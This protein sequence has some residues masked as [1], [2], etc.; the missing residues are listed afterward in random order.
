MFGT[1]YTVRHSGFVVS[2]EAFLRRIVQ[3]SR[4]MS[5]M[6]ATVTNRAWGTWIVCITLFCLACGRTPLLP[7]TCAIAIDPSVLDFGVVAPADQ[8]TESVRVSNR[9][10]RDCHLSGVGLVSGSDLWFA[11]AP[12][13]PAPLVVKSDDSAT[14]AVTFSPVSVS[15]PLQRTGVLVF[16]TD[17][18][19]HGK[20][21]VPLVAQIQSHCVLAV[22]PSA[23]DF[24]HVHLDDTAT[25]SVVVTNVGS[26]SCEI[27]KLV[28][29][30]GSDPQFSLGVNQTDRFT[31]APG[32]TQSIALS[33][34][35]VDSAVPHHRKGQLVFA[36]TDPKRLTVTIPLSADIDV[37]CALT[38]SPDNLNFGNV[39]LNTTAN[40]SVKLS[41]D[42]SD[43]CQVSG[44]RIDPSSDVG[45]SLAVGQTFAF[46]VEPGASKAINIKFG[47]FDSEPPHQKNGALLLQTGN[48][49]APQASVPLSAYVNTVCVEASRWI[50]TVDEDGMFSRFDPTTSTFTD[51][52]MLACPTFYTPFSMA[53]DQNAVAW[54]LYSDGSLFRVDASTGKCQA[55]N[56][57]P[58][59]HGL[60]VFGMGFVFD[61][62]TGVDTLFIADGAINSMTESELAT[63]SFPSLEVTPIGTVTA[64]SPE[65]SGTGD[66]SLWGFIPSEASANKQATLVRLDPTSGA[67]LESY[68][69]REL[70]DVYGDWAM[71]FWGGSFWIFLGTSIYEVLRAKPD[72]INTTIYS[73]RSI[74]GAG[75]STCAP[76]RQ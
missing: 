56:Y 53:V 26:G 65:L 25:R 41:N 30:K 73:G 34:A 63:V 59:Q 11:V 5:N 38:I 6:G 4:D 46:T 52:G 10:G 67:T 7:P 21:E 31:I 19:T 22:L 47:A 12:D 15:V 16:Q 35:A 58:K 2:C 24:G 17:D 57:E 3:E 45:F 36:S 64:G 9:G 74:V 51:I 49:K 50:Y 55:T 29:A 70:K 1:V 61:P 75:V 27:A 71:K 68:S 23:V 66:G 54:V 42:G 40:A 72:A 48:P 32:E 76:L 8:V 28:L 18:P 60:K 14:L 37:G 13:T 39:M 20:V 62:S 69:Y 33:F 44:I 43:A